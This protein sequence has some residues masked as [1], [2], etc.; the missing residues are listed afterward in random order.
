[1][2][3]IQPKRCII[4][5]RPGLPEVATMKPDRDVSWDEAMDG[6]RSHDCVPVEANQAMYILYTSGTTGNM[7]VI[8]STLQ[9]Y[10]PLP[11]ILIWFHW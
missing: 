10:S 11:H 6:D 8:T 7:R 2:S 3:G 9:F 5:Q 1:M 4:Y